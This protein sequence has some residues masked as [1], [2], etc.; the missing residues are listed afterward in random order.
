[1][2]LQHLIF[3]CNAELFGLEN[4]K[5]YIKELLTCLLKQKIRINSVQ[6]D[7]SIA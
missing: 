1:M 6:N 5:P 7:V 4:D 2:I 3:N